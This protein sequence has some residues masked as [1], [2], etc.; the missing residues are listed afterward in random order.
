MDFQNFRPWLLGWPRRY[1]RLVQVAA[2][3]AITWMA[4]WLGFWIRLGS[5]SLVN[6][7]G[8]HLWL[9]V[10]APLGKV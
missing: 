6:P 5:D 10:C 1:K 7:F 8:D 4:L 3:I 9:F 2:D